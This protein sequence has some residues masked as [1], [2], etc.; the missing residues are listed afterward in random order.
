MAPGPTPTLTMDAP[1]F[2]QI[3]GALGGDHIA[4]RQ[5]QTQVERRDRLDRVDHL[6]LVAVCGVDH[7]HV[8]AGLGEGGGL[9]RDV[10]VDADRRG[11]PQPAGRVDSGRVDACADGA[12]SGQDAGQRAVGFDEHRHIDRGV[13]EQVVHLARVGAH[14]GGDQLGGCDVA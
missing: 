4:R 12:G 11:D 9:R 8:D 6:V 14:G 13:F 1:A 2:D 3:A 5:R 7:E 10:S